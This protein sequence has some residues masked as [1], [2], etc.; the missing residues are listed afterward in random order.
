MDPIIRSRR[1]RW[2]LF[3]VAAVT[4]VATI[5]TCRSVAD[6]VLAARRGTQE[7]A[8]CVSECAHAANDAIRAESD[9]HVQNVH[10]CAGDSACLAQEEARHDAAVDAI[11]G[12]RKACQDGCRHQGGGAGGR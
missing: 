10:A 4:L 6:N 12:Q 1:V 11:Q 2:A 5:D 8:N 7:T 9:L 3:A